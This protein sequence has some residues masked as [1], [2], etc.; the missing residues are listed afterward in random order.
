MIS[1]YITGIAKLIESAPNAE[2][3]YSR[4]ERHWYLSRNAITH[5]D[6]VIELI[7]QTINQYPKNPPP[8]KEL[9]R[10][11][12]DALRS[13]GFLSVLGRTWGMRSTRR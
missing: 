2:E 8:G 9:S 12:V 7:Q 4:L 11:T 6:E 3:V 1:L 13:A 10:D 5:R